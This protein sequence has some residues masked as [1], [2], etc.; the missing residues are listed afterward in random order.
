MAKEEMDF[1]CEACDMDFDSRRELDD[2]NAEAHG[3]A[4]GEPDGA[5]ESKGQQTAKP[6]R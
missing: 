5:E 6:R 4:A 1:G 2:H 3:D